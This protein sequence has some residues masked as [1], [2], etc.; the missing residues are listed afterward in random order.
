[1][2]SEALT[3]NKIQGDFCPFGSH[4]NIKAAYYFYIKNG[5]NINPKNDNSLSKQISMDD[6][7]DYKTLLKKEGSLIYLPT[8]DNFEQ[9]NNKET[10]YEK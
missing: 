8:M 3:A 6:V 2:P 10:C 7:L 4:V 5:F 9:I 1:M